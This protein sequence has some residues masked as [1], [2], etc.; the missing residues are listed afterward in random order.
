LQLPHA[1][2]S[3]ESMFHFEQAAHAARSAW[4]YVD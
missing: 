4:G 2:H 1:D 3:A